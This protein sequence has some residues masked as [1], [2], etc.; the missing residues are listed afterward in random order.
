[1]LNSGGHIVGV[2]HSILSAGA[3]IYAGELDPPGLIMEDCFI[4]ADAPP[5]TLTRLLQAA[6]ADLVKAGARLLLASGVAGGDWEKRIP[7]SGLQTAHI[8]LCENRPEC[9]RVLSIM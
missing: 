4:Q 6:E 3:P 7:A 9:K 5:E 8:V 2:T 1:M